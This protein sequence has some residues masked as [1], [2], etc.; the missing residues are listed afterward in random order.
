MTETPY[1]FRI[2]GPTWEARRLVDAAA[3]LAAYARRDE[4]AEVQREAYLSAFRFGEDFRRLLLETGSTAGYSGPCWSPW[5]WWDID[6]EGDLPRGQADAEALAE[7][8]TT[9]YQVA[10]GDLLV[11][12][13]GSKGFHVGLPTVLWSPAPSA[14]FN[15]TARR[16][17]EHVAELAG[18]AIDT[19]VYDRVRAFRAPNSRHPK[20]GLHKRRLTLDELRGP[21]DGILELAKTPVPFTL[22]TV[23]KISDQAAADWAAAVGLVKTEGKAKVAR[24]AAGN[25]TPTLNRSTVAFIREG[26]GTGDRHRLLFSAAANLAEFGCSPALAVALLE[27]SALDSGLPPKDVRRQVECG[28]AAAGS[29]TQQDAGQSPQTD[30][31]G[32]TVKEPPEAAISDSGGLGGQAGQQVTT[33]PLPAAVDLQT[34]L[35]KLWGSTPATPPT[36]AAEGPPD[37]ATPAPSGVADQA[38]GPPVLPS[39]PPPLRPL[40]PGA[41][42]SGKLDTPCKCGST[43]YVELPIPEGRTRRDCR[44]C[45]HFVG[46]GRWHDQ[47]GPTP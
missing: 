14:D 6:A 24:R 29:A 43:E 11:F 33:A 17:A 31:D 39:D 13:S 2:V 3:A 32:S 1:G 20:T 40:P 26:A 25:G 8:L 42:G 18:V 46:W 28:L 34:A 37:D 19:G 10:A 16:F 22:P 7:V 9:R 23:A 27:E 5:L 21:L 45:G 35:A 12:F 36:D 4:K 41:V 47:G 30:P 44:K 15:R 38:K